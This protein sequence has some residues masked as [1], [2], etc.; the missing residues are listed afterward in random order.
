ML[1]CP[2]TGRDGAQALARRLLEKTPVMCSAALPPDR[3]QTVSIGIAVCENPTVDS[4]ALLR[5]A[6]QAMYAAKSSGRNRY[7]LADPAITI[8]VR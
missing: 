1:V 6:D 8:S 4:M 5:H 2:G 3:L 7:V